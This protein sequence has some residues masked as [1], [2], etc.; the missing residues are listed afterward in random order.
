MVPNGAR[1]LTNGPS[2]A[3]RLATSGG[4]A[5]LLLP[6]LPALVLAAPPAPAQIERR[7]DGLAI[8]EDPSDERG[9]RLS[10]PIDGERPTGQPAIVRFGLL[11]LAEIAGQIGLGSGIGYTR[12]LPRTPA[13]AGA[14]EILLTPRIVS[15]PLVL[16]LALGPETVAAL[17][18]ALAVGWVDASAARFAAVPVDTHS[19]PGLGLQVGLGLE[20]RL[21]GLLGLSIHG[22][23]RSLR[24]TLQA[25]R[26]SRPGDAGPAQPQGMDVDLS[27]PYLLASLTAWL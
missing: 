23:Y 16:R 7:T 11:Y 9:L 27:G 13:G 24:P 4:A 6:L 15:V 1:K 21:A 5:A 18:P 26:G 20:T 17:E 12:S 8:R 19:S 14:G 2:R 10:L 22:G 25:S 3:A